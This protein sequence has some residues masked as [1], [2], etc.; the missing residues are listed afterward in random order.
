MEKWPVYGS[1]SMDCVWSRVLREMVRRMCFG[2]GGLPIFASTPAPFVVV[3]VVVVELV[4]LCISVGFEGDAED[5]GTEEKAGVRSEGG[6]FISRASVR[7][8]LD[9]SKAAFAW[10]D[11]DGKTVSSELGFADIASGSGRTGWREKRI[12]DA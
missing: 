6:V 10:E 7:G 12:G 11:S 2:G 3:V 8:E 9:G 1:D 4:S 5:D